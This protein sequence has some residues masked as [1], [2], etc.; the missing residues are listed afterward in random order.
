MAVRSFASYDDPDFKNYLQAHFPYFL[1]CHDGTDSTKQILQDQSDQISGP[2]K[3][4]LALCKM[5]LFFIDEGLNVALVNGLQ[6]KDTKI[7]TTVLEK[8]S[9]RMNMQ[10]KP[11]LP[12][13]IRSTS[14]PEISGFIE[15]L[16][17][18]ELELSER[19]MLVI[20][21]VTSVLQSKAIELSEKALL[22]LSCLFIIHAAL[23]DHISLSSRRLSTPE[24]NLVPNIFLREIGMKFDVILNATEWKQGVE[25]RN[26]VADV[27]DCIDGRLFLHICFVT[28]APSGPVIATVQKLFKGVQTLLGHF[29]PFQDLFEPHSPSQ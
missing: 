26:I 9:N 10:I 3:Q 27:A 19:Q 22:K 11:S 21:G 23:L 13:T 15:K 14:M 16:D 17:Q 20:L 1:M 24:A 2:S 25:R 6:W 29:E 28:P 18:L 8:S 4:R 5:I 7:I 12:A